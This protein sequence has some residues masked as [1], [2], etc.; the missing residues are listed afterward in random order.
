MITASHRLTKKTQEILA[1][2]NGEVLT[3]PAAAKALALTDTATINGPIYFIGMLVVCGTE[4]GQMN[5]T[6]DGNLVF[7]CKVVSAGTVD[8]RLLQFPVY[9]PTGVTCTKLF[10]NGATFVLYYVEAV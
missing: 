5:V 6:A 3:F 9:C 7:A 8:C 4:S 10:G 1:T 2:G